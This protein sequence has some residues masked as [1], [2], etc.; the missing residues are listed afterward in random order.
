MNQ[1]QSNPN[2]NPQ[3]DSL[4]NFNPSGNPSA[5]NSNKVHFSPSNANLDSLNSKPKFDNPVNDNQ[6][7]NYQQP[8]YNPPIPQNDQF[9]SY[10]P[11]QNTNTSIQ[12]F[13][14]FSPQQN[15]DTG[16]DNQGFNPSS[17]FNQ[18]GLDQYKSATPQFNSNDPYL[19]PSTIPEN[20]DLDEFEPEAQEKPQRDTKKIL[21]FGLIGLIVVLLVASLALFFLSQNNRTPAV[22]N[23]INPTSSKP[24]TQGLPA[25]QNPTATESSADQLPATNTASKTGNPNTPASQS[26]VNL[27]ANAVA[28]DWLQ[29]NFAKFKGSLAEDGTCKL[30]N[31]CGP[32]VDPDKDGLNNLDE[33]IFATDPNN[34]DVDA[35]GLSDKDELY[36]YYSDP[37]NPDTNSNTY[38]DGVEV[39]NCYDPNIA[40]QKLSKSRLNEISSNV[41][42]PHVN[43]LS[44]TTQSTFKA[45]GGTSGELEKGYLT[46]CAVTSSSEDPITPKAET[47][48]K[49]S[50]T[51]PQR[52]PNQSVDVSDSEGA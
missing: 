16:F 46:K 5:S 51:S 34:P 31:V 14:N 48:N 12:D 44:V 30:Q 10:N 21:M 36:I 52:Q 42:K 17:D 22:N 38:K 33:Y 7:I 18:T 45:S 26:V 8:N 43:G 6:P 20:D 47:S 19:M 23:A 49:R 37:K 39:S 40:S 50:P 2:Y 35:D 29:I 32:K 3:N 9:G 11:Y 41:N 25:T 1:D 4:Q 27:G 15:F 28:N 13:Q 24:T